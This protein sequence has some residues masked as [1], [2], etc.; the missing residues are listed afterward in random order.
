MFLTAGA[1]GAMGADT[2]LAH[3]G[4][5]SFEGGPQPRQLGA[6]AR[7]GQDEVGLTWEESLFGPR[8]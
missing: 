5:G 2:R 6:E 3:L 1:G 7:A 8:H 4:E